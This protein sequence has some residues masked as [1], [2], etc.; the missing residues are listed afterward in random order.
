MNNITTGGG[1][2]PALTSNVAAGLI[3]KADIDHSHSLGDLSGTLPVSQ[4]GTGKSSLTAYSVPYA[5]SSSALAFPTAAAG[6]LYKTSATGAPIFGVLPIAQGGTGSTS[7][8][9][10]AEKISN[11]PSFHPSKVLVK[12]N[13]V[14]EVGSTNYKN[15][16]GYSNTGDFLPNAGIGWNQSNSSGYKTNA[17]FTVDYTGLYKFTLSDLTPGITSDSGGNGNKTVTEVYL[18]NA[19]T[20]VSPGWGVLKETSTGVIQK[21]NLSSNYTY[22]FKLD[23]NTNYALFMNHG[24]TVKTTI[25][26]GVVS[27]SLEL[28]TE[29]NNFTQYLGKLSTTSDSIVID[30]SIES[31]ICFSGTGSYILELG[32]NVSNTTV[33]SSKIT[34]NTSTRTLKLYSSTSYPVYII[35]LPS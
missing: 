22:Q 2:I 23:I 10:L 9:N 35:G 5:S 12:W 6:A 19:D 31:C 3:D 14:A 24:I 15:T 1:Q 13:S 11:S 27:A 18:V 8:D 33:G 28:M 34:Y 29:P 21:F 4:G 7:L 16:S 32:S 25:Q 30:S 26:P 17:S 20:F